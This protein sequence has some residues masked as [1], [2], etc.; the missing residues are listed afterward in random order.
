[1]ST[2]KL[3]NV[4]LNDNLV[5]QEIKKEIKGLLGFNENEET[6]YQNLWDTMKV[7]VSGKLIALSASRKKLERAYT[8]SLTAPLKDLEWK[9]INTPKRSI[10][11][12]IIKLMAEINQIETKN[13]TKIN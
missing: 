3:N 7:V 13:Y 11:Q 9:E 8:S 10:W 4:L 2:W 12:E 5:K 1:M 6:A